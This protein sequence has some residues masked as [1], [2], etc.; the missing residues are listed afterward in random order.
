[1]AVSGLCHL[2][3]P[4]PDFG[5]RKKACHSSHLPSS[6]SGIAGLRLVWVLASTPRAPPEWYSLPLHNLCHGLLPGLLRTYH[7]VESVS[8]GSLKENFLRRL[9]LRHWRDFLRSWDL[10]P[11]S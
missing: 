1:M 5:S 11:P 7:L 10:L 2:Q 4:F 9:D 8:G 3:V 6:L